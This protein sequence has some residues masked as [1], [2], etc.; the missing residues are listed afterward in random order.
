MS[1]NDKC[2]QEILLICMSC[3]AQKPSGKY[4]PLVDPDSKYAYSHGY[5]SKEC[6]AK[7]HGEY[8]AGLMDDVITWNP[9][10]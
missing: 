5:C 8:I 10:K 6:V 1:K 7:H 3:G 9:N 2:L 4:T